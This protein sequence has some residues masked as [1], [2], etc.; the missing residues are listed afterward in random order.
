MPGVQEVE[1]DYDKS[2]AKVRYDSNITTI[3]VM[4]TS[5]GG[6]GYKSWDTATETRKPATE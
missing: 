1:V 5:L 3:A 4:T 2:V 6:A